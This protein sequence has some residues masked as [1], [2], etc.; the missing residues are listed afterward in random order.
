MDQL[1]RCIAGAE[2]C[3]A[4]AVALTFDDGYEDA[5]SVVLPALQRRGMLATFYIVSG[6][7]GQPGYVNWEQVRALH[8]AGMEI[9]SHTVAHPDLTTLAPDQLRYELAE[10]KAQIE[11]AIGQPVLSFCYPAGRFNG[12]IAALVAELG[13]TNATTT[14]PDLPQGDLMLLPRLRVD[15]SYGSAEF[16]WLVP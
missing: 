12:D 13:Y 1:A 5:F 9:G 2:Q 10:S 7:V 14:L 3:P 6:F 15:G 8:A 16:Q 11:A 4:H